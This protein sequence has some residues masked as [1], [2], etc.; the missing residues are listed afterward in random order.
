MSRSQRKA[1]YQQQNTI[2]LQWIGSATSNSAW[3][4]KRE[5]A[6]TSSGKNQYA[7]ESGSRAFLN[8]FSTLS[9]TAAFSINKS[10]HFYLPQ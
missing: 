5:W 1:M 9:D 4:R 7:S 8:D 10:V 3:R 2:I 6:G